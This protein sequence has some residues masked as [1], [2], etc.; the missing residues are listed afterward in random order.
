MFIQVFI[1][2]NIGITILYKSLTKLRE[3]VLTNR[4]NELKNIFYSNFHNVERVGIT[5]RVLLANIVKQ[6]F[7]SGKT[8]CKLV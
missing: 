5:K 6:A 2:Q 4:L 1:K 7:H 8:T 3:R